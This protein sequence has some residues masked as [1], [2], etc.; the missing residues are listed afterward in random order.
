MVDTVLT[1][2]T[3]SL[4][5]KKIMKYLFTLAIL[6]LF[7]LCIT[8]QVD[9]LAGRV[10]TAEQM[11]QDLAFLRNVVEKTHPGLYRYT[12]KEQ[13]QQKMD[14]VAGLLDKSM[15]FY[16]YYRLLAALIADVRCA[17]TYVI[18]KKDLG[19]YFSKEARMLP[20]EIIPAG[21]R[22]Y[23]TLNGTADT[24]IRPG[25]E[26]TAINGR[27]TSEIMKQL[28]RH[29]WTD[30][31]IRSFKTS[32][33]TGA[34]FGLFYYMMVEQP[35]HFLLTLRDTAGR[36]MEIN[37]PAL[38]NKEYFP[39]FF[40]NP[41]NQALIALYKD[42][43]KK[44]Q[45]QGWR[46]EMLP[47]PGTALLRIN[48]FGG[49]KDAKGAAR[50]MRDFMAKNVAALKK[51]KISHLIVDLRNN[52]GG[53]DIQGVELFTWLAKDTTPFRFYRRKHTITNS[54]EFL[55]YSDLSADDI[56]HIKDELIP[57]PDSTFTLREEY[58]LDMKIYYPKPDRF[59][60]NL[61]FLVNGGTGSSASEFTALA[62]HHRLGVFIGNE[63]GGAYA[64]GNGGSFLHFELPNSRISLGTPLIY[65]LNE[66]DMPAQTGR[67]VLPD[68]P[69]Q[70]TVSDLLQA[71]DAPVEK[72][73]EL[74][75]E[76]SNH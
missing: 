65:Y 66:V 22:L 70:A 44:D 28:Y 36:T 34:R 31:F 62:H 24:A 53:W 15:A 33:L 11:Q 64:G 40:S 21:D 7:R 69:V 48:A 32:Q 23:I 16:D 59:T 17:H 18:P 20:F 37:A 26:I 75:R 12:S 55:R 38:T 8:A 74:I 3:A 47:Q 50:K 5:A 42:R 39:R 71:R 27:A 52:S 56:A 43:N 30:G 72:A 61:Y 57:E 10:L 14:S 68:Y 58:N 45:D 73:L 46:L 19:S 54:A 1:N 67:G 2:E 51:N 49:G 29:I 13:M 60:G 63:T 6:L 4:Q 9:P 35:D 25:Y 76:K 41:V